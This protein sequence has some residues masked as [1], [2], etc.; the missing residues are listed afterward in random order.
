MR[1]PSSRW[2]DCLEKS[3]EL[4]WTNETNLLR[5]IMPWLAP[6][7][8]PVLQALILKNGREASFK[9]GEY[10]FRPDEPIHSLV[11]VRRGI[12]LRGAGSASAVDMPAA[13]YSTPGRLACGNLNFFTRLPCAGNYS[14]ATDCSVV[15]CPQDT[16]SEILKNDPSLL[17]VVAKHFELCILSDRLGFLA[18]KF[19]TVEQRLSCYL[20]SW[21]TYYGRKFVR[22]N[23][24]TVI[25]VPTP[26]RGESLRNV[27]GCSNA[28]F[29]KA[30]S[31]FYDSP[32]V[33]R[34]NEWIYIRPDY[35]KDVHEWLS[36]ACEGSMRYRE[37]GFC[38]NDA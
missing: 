1:I 21:C 30:I 4:F 29:Q 22:E 7:V 3:E 18:H 35:M 5:P 37:L 33:E 24:S 32:L 34:D 10:L 13:A 25:H 27:L 28:A 9:A 17:A 6:P 8:Y 16:L 38:F 14:A 19:L 15:F 36:L 11:L 20:L 26:L 2:L 31:D 23:G 12:T